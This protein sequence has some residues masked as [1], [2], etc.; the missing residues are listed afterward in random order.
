[1]KKK[2]PQPQCDQ[3]NQKSVPQQS[4]GP[5]VPILPYLPFPG[6]TPVIPEF[7]V[8]VFFPEPIF[9]MWY[10]LPIGRWE[11]SQSETSLGSKLN[12]EEEVKSQKTNPRDRRDEKKDLPRVI[13]PR[14][15]FRLVRSN[16]N[17]PDWKKDVGREFRV[18]YYSKQDGLDVIWLVNEDGKYEQTTD[19]Q[20]LLKYF[21]PVEISD[22][23]DMYGSAKPQLRRLRKASVSRQ[24]AKVNV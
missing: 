17:T 3:P 16:T 6:V 23:S 20:F 14:S 5:V 7:P 19:R 2:Q 15:I 24:R 4:P 1:V 13:P 10:W 11:A 22:E 12:S 18:G 21:E 8:P 9:V